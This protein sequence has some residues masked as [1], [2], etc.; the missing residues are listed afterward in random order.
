[1]R[2]SL[3]AF[4]FASAPPLVKKNVSMS[5]GAIAASFC[6]SLARASV[7]MKGLAYAS[8]SACRWM[9][10]TTRGSPWPMLTHI[11]WLL[12]S[13]KRRLSGVQNQHPFAPATGIGSTEA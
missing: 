5:P 10:R 1:M 7:A 9:A 8:V 2:A 3:I 13:R 11:S 12:K 6:P 4:S